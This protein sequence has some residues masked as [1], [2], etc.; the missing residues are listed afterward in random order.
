LLPAD[1]RAWS[2]SGAASTGQAI[3]S[4]RGTAY[5]FKTS[6]F[7]SHWVW[8]VAAIDWPSGT[9]TPVDRRSD[10]SATWSSGCLAALP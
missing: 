9:V 8:T 6:G 1:S 7:L 5:V 10:C 2:S 4:V 3:I